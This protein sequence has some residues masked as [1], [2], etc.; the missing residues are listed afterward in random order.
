MIQIPKQ[1]QKE[2]FRFILLGKAKKEP[3][4]LEW[5]KENN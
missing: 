1:L 3:I 5:Q 2:E 4:E